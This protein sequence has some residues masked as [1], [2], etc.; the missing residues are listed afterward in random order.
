M[1]GPAHSFDLD[2]VIEAWPV[3][4]GALSPPL[5]AAIQDA[6][7][8]SVEGSV[9]IFGVPP[10]RLDAIRKRFQ[11]EADTIRASLAAGLGGVPQFKLRA[12]D[13]DAPGAL[14]PAPAGA[15]GSATTGSAGATG[16]ASGG[17]GAVE[18]P[19]DPGDPGYPDEEHVDITDLVD[20]P[21]GPPSFEPTAALR[22][23]LGAQIV[24]ERPRE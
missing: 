3:A 1:A 24:E 5:R 17:A 13:F 10:K 7:P 9:V 23:E 18:P 14:R 2:D 21:P 15:T 8:I 12:H 6:Q 4:M 22:A 19:D 20:A 11:S 16:P